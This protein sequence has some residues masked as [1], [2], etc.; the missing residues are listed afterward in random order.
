METW[1]AERERSELEDMASKMTLF[2]LVKHV[3]LLYCNFIAQEWAPK[4]LQ[5]SFQLLQRHKCKRVA[6]ILA[7]VNVLIA[8]R[9]NV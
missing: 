4:A 8:W 6:V 5:V 2:N 7:P 9:G 3:D 1:Y